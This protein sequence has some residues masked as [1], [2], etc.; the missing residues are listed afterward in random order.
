[1]LLLDKCLYDNKTTSASVLFLYTLLY[2]LATAI[3][4][5]AFYCLFFMIEFHILA[6]IIAGMGSFFVFVGG[7]MFLLLEK[8][9]LLTIGRNPIWI[10]VNV[11]PIFG[12][13]LLIFLLIPDKWI[14]SYNN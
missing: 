8:N 6:M 12:I 2:F 7:I 14:K 11:F 4:A 13:F 9:R 5:G 3:F 10:F 1:M